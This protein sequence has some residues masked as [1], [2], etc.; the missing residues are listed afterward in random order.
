[1][2]EITKYQVT[3]INSENDENVKSYLKAKFNFREETAPRDRIEINTRINNLE[4]NSN[5]LENYLQEQGCYIPTSLISR[6]YK[7]KNTQLIIFNSFIKLGFDL[8][9]KAEGE[10]PR[11]EML[12]LDDLNKFILTG[13]IK[14]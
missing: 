10:V 13:E 1:M 12:N 14:E 9:I 2:Y 5:D 6:E 11:K 8:N 4:S 3:G 7:V